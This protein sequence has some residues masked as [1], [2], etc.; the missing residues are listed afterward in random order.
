MKAVLALLFIVALCMV[1][2]VNSS[3]LVLVAGAAVVPL[4]LFSARPDII[5]VGVVALFLSHM[6]IPAVPGERQMY[7]LLMCILFVVVIV[8]K[9]INKR[10][11]KGTWAKWFAYLFLVVLTITAIY[12]GVGF[13]SLGDYELW[14]GGRYLVIV[15]CLLFF[16]SSDSFELTTRQ[17][18]VA[19]VALLLLSVLPAVWE[20]LYLFSHGRIYY[21]YYFFTPSGSEAMTLETSEVQ[22][23]LIRVKGF[24][25][26]TMLFMLPFVVYPAKLRYILHYTLFVMLGF[27]AVGL[28][29]H[30]MGI[31]T[32]GFFVWAYFFVISKRKI[33]YIVISGLVIVLA[34][35]IL[36]Q[37][38]YYLPSNFQRA[39]CVIPFAHVS[40]EIYL[41]A[42]GTWDWRIEVWKDALEEVPRYLLIGKGYAYD[43]GA[44]IYMMRT[45]YMSDHNVQ[46][47]IVS[48][49]Y[50]QGILSL[51]LGMGI[52]G[53][54]AGL[55]YMFGV[56]RKHYLLMR[57]DWPDSE[58]ARM[59]RA[60]T[61][62]FIVDTVIYLVVY[63]DVFAS[64]PDLFFYG[65][66]LEGIRN[67]AARM[68]AEKDGLRAGD[69]RLKMNSPAV[70]IV[71]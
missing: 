36:G 4:L 53:L 31:V 13:Q 26:T 32:I 65:A 10:S 23:A 66:V 1:S 55:G 45:A 57:R 62:L 7:E 63:G 37:L 61:V 42:Q 41:D 40:Q 56:C 29:G 60:I 15:P 38:A 18:K 12:R 25:P 35:A 22:D 39:L 49:S 17:W 51:L 8:R 52:A 71:P 58:L 2:M 69:E 20:L 5:A 67:T 6:K 11:A 43:A 48:S 59:H 9:S 16:L 24:M 21:Q 14:G 50:H 46:W 19:L 3:I 68:N 34:C 30:R 47:A 33:G 64:F 27:V 44:Y 54:V 28:T 70:A